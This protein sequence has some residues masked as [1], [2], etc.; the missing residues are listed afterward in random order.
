MSGEKLERRMRTD[1]NQKARRTADGCERDL[2][3]GDVGRADLKEYP[4]GCGFNQKELQPKI[5]AQMESQRGKEKK[6]LNVDKNASE[7]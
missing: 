4:L 1:I 5:L 7:L 2:L 3:Y 6:C